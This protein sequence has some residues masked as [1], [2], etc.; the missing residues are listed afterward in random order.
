AQAPSYDISPDRLHSSPLHARP[1]RPLGYDRLPSRDPERCG[2]SAARSRRD[3]D[4]CV[5]RLYGHHVRRNGIRHRS[6]AARLQYRTA[7]R[8]LEIAIYKK[9]QRGTK[10]TTAALPQRAA[11]DSAVRYLISKYSPKGNKVGWLMMA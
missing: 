2:Q 5:D 10:M 7:A 4:R 1:C 8:H 9:T 3:S 11:M 6:R